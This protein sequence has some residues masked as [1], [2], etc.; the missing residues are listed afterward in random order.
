LAR[1]LY[2]FFAIADMGFGTG[3]TVAAFMARRGER[4]RGVEVT[5]TVAVEFMERQSKCI[6]ISHFRSPT[7]SIFLESQSTQKVEEE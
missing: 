3:V 1:R 2:F 4:R 6:T 5:V 7:L